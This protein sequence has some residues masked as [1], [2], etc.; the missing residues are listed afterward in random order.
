MTTDVDTLS[1]AAYSTAR[2]GRQ[3][4]KV[5]RLWYYIFMP[6]TA[7][8]HSVLPLLKEHYAYVAKLDT[9]EY[10]GST[11]MGSVAYETTAKL[12]ITTSKD[13]SKQLTLPIC[14]ERETENTRTK[15]GV[16]MEVKLEKANVKFEK[17]KKKGPQGSSVKRSSRADVQNYSSED[18]NA[19]LD[20]AELHTPLGH[21]HWA[22]V[23]EGFKAFSIENDR[24][25]RDLDSLRNKFDKLCNSK[26]PTGSA[27]C[28]PAVRRA[29]KLLATSNVRQRLVCLGEMMTS[30]TSP[31]IRTT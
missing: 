21:N 25:F 23:A 18:T 9:S 17:G 10:T 29:K 26:Q 19:L 27:D 28:P 3:S 31:P 11:A 6:N 5:G 8:N 14:G 7:F 4:S 22:M 12:F 13:C 2:R 15:R 1:M 20:L 30:R 24:P 16:L